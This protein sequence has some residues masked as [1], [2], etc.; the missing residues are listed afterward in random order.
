M[1]CIK[2]GT[3]IPVGARFCNACGEPVSSVKT[4]GLISD[5]ETVIAQQPSQKPQITRDQPELVIFTVRPTLLFVKI[6]YVAAFF[7]AAILGGILLY[8]GVVFEFPIWLMIFA[9]SLALLLF[10]IPAYYHFRRNIVRYT[11][12]DAKLEIDTGFFNRQTQ[13]VALGKIQDVT[14]SANFPQRLFGY[15]NLVID[16]A[17]EIGGTIVLKNINNPRQHADLILREMRRLKS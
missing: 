6:G 17:G 11:L 10:L 5:E 16:N 1:F 4:P 8:L 12:T 2:C 15:G 13:F 3:K 14:V 7:G 9:V